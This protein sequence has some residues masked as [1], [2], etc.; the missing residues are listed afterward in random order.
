MLACATVAN[1][2]GFNSLTAP[3]AW[4]TQEYVAFALP[5]TAG[6]PDTGIHTACWPRTA[7]S[8][9][10]SYTWTEGASY[11]NFAF[12]VAYRNVSGIDGNTAANQ[13][14]SFS[15]TFS[16]ADAGKR[17]CLQKSSSASN[18]LGQTC[19]TITAYNPPAA[20]GLSSITL[21]F[22]PGTLV[23][24]VEAV[25]ASDDYPD[26]HTMLSTA[27]CAIP[28]PGCHVYLSSK[29]GLSSG[30]ALAQGNLAFAMGGDGAGMPWS[31]NDFL[32]G[33]PP[34]D[35]GTQLVFLTTSLSSTTPGLLI[36]GGSTLNS[37]LANV[38]LDRFSLIGGAGDNGD[39]A[40]GDGLDV[41]NWQ[42]LK[43]EGVQIANFAGNG[44]LLDGVSGPPYSYTENTVFDF[45]IITLNHG[46]A[47]KTGSN[48]PNIE[49]VAVTN[50]DIEGN[51]GPAFNITSP[52]AVQ[53]LRIESNTIQWNN[54]NAAAAE[55]TLAATGQITG[56]D[57]R[58]NYFE[59]D[60]V[61]GGKSNAV[62]TNVAAAIGCEWGN[63]KNFFNAGIPPYLTFSAAGTPLPACSASSAALNAS[64]AYVTDA[65]ACT[66]GTTYT[67]GGST[68]CKVLC[69]GGN[70]VETGY[71][72][73]Y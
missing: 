52:G 8:E 15:G 69:T 67:S 20:G 65:T 9:P 60:N 62:L 11:F 68:A 66:S 23:S 28:G 19:G 58:G 24:G 13:L 46:A 14:Q 70:W 32:S 6:N 40:G 57:I 54:R 1:A 56:C 22:T 72:Y 18:G 36:S 51:G 30:L 64:T 53:G 61:F 27:P 4:G 50:S 41:L 48:T 10:S 34:Q 71:G 2:G 45:G 42:G 35:S 26:F 17:I 55:I 25:Y 43:A 31:A 33:V 21:S 7:S 39:G 16:S 49:T 59:P 5:N 12:I 3:A 44:I 73:P 37:S 29:Y 63:N 47:I 38:E